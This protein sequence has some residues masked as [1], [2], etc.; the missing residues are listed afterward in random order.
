MPDDNPTPFSLTSPVTTAF[1]ITSPFNSPRSYANGRHEGIDLRAVA[2]GKAVEV[3]AAQRGVV[4]HISLGGTDFGNYVRIR[5]NW[6]DGT[7]WV[8]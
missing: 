7:T 3:V 6:H 5:H 2:N 4:D 8:T 1:F